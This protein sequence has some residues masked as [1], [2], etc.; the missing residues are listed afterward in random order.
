M[1]KKKVIA[2]WFIAFVLLFLYS[3]TQI[4]LGLTFSRAGLFLTVETLFQH[5]GYYM[6]P[7]SSTLAAIIFIVLFCL[8]CLTLRLVLLEKLSEKT[9]WI[10][11]ILGSVALLFSY[12]AFSYDLF[13]YI[14]DAKIVTHYHANPYLHKAL[15]YPHDPMLGFMHWTQRT[16]PYGPLWLVITIPLSILGLGYF[17]LTFFLFKALIVFS[18]LIISYFILKTLKKT[19]V[20]SPN[21]GLAFFALNPLVIVEGL[22][23]AHIDFTMTAACVVS[24]YFLFSHKNYSSWFFLII[25]VFIKF[26][27]FLLMPLYIWYP[28]SK[29]KNKNSIFILLS[30]VMMLLG[31]ILASMR[32]TFQPWYFILVLPFV[33][34]VA[35]KYYISIP[36]I[37]FSFL[38]LFQY[39]PYLYTGGYKP[40]VP[41]LMNQMLIVA[42]IVSS[43]SLLF[44][45]IFTRR[46]KR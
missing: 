4:D 9:L 32:T 19:K 24:V 15:D 30:I 20:A 16:F 22:V 2:F 36:S 39:L 3:Y 17:I 7:L 38:I 1:L 28:F 14:F 33:A 8:Y 23:S 13:N 29:R 6:R 10:I 11:I 41:L 40:P 5:I 18:Y 46:E 21:F 37:I 35:K 34:L 25:S 31:M 27:T 26:A 44:V 12:N 45:K 42:A 43:G